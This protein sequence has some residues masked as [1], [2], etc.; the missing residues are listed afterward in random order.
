MN[1]FE[2]IAHYFAPLAKLDGAFGLTDDAAL[3]RVPPECELVLTT[4][5]LHAGVHFFAD[6]QAGLIA[7]KALR[8]NLS[9][10]AAMGARP[11]GYLLN[12]SLPPGTCE[13]WLAAF[14][15][16]LRE[17]QE[18]YGLSLLGGD[19]TATQGPLSI[20]ITALGMTEAG[21]ALRRSGAQAGETVYVSGTIGDAAIGLTQDPAYEACN[22]RYL[23]PLPRVALAQAIAPHVRACLD[24]SDGL[25]QD[26][27][28]LCRASGVGATI[29]A[30][31]VPLSPEARRWLAAGGEL[32]ALLSGGDD[33]ELL[34]AAPSQAEA[35]LQELAR[36]QGVALSAIGTL[37]LTQGEVTIH[38]AHGQALRFGR[39]GYQHF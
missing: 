38:D 13:D 16:G 29:H 11:Y 27:G 10:L 33:Y 20:T 31:Q 6:T 14:A 32:S 36:A 24:I 2:R 3:L 4:D 22:L 18:A 5:T 19:S 21:G 37:T 9:D 26:L 30:Q 15:G 17:D 23:L 28:H 1:E 39:S 34:F 12:L 7:K 35:A 25:A 8:V